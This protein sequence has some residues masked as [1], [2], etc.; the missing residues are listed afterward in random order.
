MA[1]NDF[2]LNRCLAS[3]DVASCEAL[4]AF[5]SPFLFYIIMNK[6]IPIIAVIGLAVIAIALVSV[7][8]SQSTEISSQQDMIQLDSKLMVCDSI[9][10]NAN[11]YSMDAQR[12]A[13]TS[14]MS[15]TNTAIDRHGS[16]ADQA[17]WA[18]FV[19]G[20]ERE[21]A[22][23]E[24]MLREGLSYC[25]TTFMGQLLALNACIA[26]MNAQFTDFRS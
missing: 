19:E 21:I 11:P 3:L 23:N 17:E 16:T 8:G 25:N 14:Y 18:S 1:R 7:I 5:I 22:L 13:W 10:V 9:I 2:K 24:M 15:C 6:Q 20:N 26:D 12:D 4:D